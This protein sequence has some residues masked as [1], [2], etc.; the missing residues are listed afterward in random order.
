MDNQGDIFY[1]DEYDQFYKVDWTIT[2]DLMDITT[3]VMQPYTYSNQA[4]YVTAN[5][6]FRKG[7][8]TVKRQAFKL[9]QG[10][11]I[12]QAEGI[13]SYEDFIQM[14]FPCGGGPSDK[15]KY[16]LDN[17][18]V[19]D[20]EISVITGPHWA[21]PNDI[22]DAYMVWGDVNNDGSPVDITATGG[23]T[24]LEWIDVWG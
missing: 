9:I 5:T 1:K 19:D 13:E 14:T 4:G 23:A 16:H 18:P 11:Y 21:D 20:F 8:I 6:I 24:V 22:A 7:I 15:F 12:L 17:L 10:G 2:N 3:I